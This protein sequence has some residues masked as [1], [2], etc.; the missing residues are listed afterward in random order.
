MIL[1]PLFGTSLLVAVTTGPLNDPMG[2][3]HL[4]PREKTAATQEGDWFLS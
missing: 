1:A 3:T 2:V 4:S